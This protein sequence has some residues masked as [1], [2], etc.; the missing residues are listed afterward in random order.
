MY[1]KYCGSKIND[2]AIF[3]AECGKKIKKKS[4]INQ[5]IVS[6]SNLQNNSDNNHKKKKIIGLAVL[7]I[8][9]IG[10]GVL[11]F[12]GRSYKKVIDVYV[13]SSMS[14]KAK[15]VEKMYKLLPE[16]VQ[17]AVNEFLTAYKNADGEKCGELLYNNIF[18]EEISFSEMQRL[19]AEK[20]SWKIKQNFFEW[21]KDG[22]V[23]I[24]I[25]NIDFEEI[26]KEFEG[27]QVT[28]EEITATISKAKAAKSYDC[29]VTV[30]KY[31]RK[32]K[33]I[34][35]DTLSN[36]LFGGLNEYLQKNMG[37]ADDKD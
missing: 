25:K 18:E 14:G 35:T 24:R 2:T 13:K 31:G 33:I 22:Q 20:I 29:K 36:A 17:D 34:M 8:A 11:I 7:C 3:C 9:I 5:D 15:D 28:E 12:G 21:K 19:L 16:E 32:Y 26:A 6:K 1:C 23:E 10:I 4:A 37:Y 30:S 27:K